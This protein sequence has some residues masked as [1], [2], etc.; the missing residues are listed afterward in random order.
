MYAH[1]Y[2]SVHIYVSAHV[3]V[4]CYIPTVSSVESCCVMAFF[5]PST[6]SPKNSNG[7]VDLMEEWA[8]LLP[9]WILENVLE[10]FLMPKIQAEVDSWDPTTDTVPIHSWIHP[11]LP[12]LS[13]LAPPLLWSL[14]TD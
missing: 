6:W 12:I 10:Q 7:M 8:P 13:K 2:V 9:P 5:S 3:H 14:V 11:W 1:V 4:S